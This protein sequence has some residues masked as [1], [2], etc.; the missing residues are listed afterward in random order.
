MGI[1]A[2]ARLDSTTVS[3]LIA[4]MHDASNH[5][6]ILPAD[7]I[8]L[9]YESLRKMHILWAC[10]IYNPILPSVSGLEFDLCHDSLFVQKQYLAEAPGP[11]PLQGVA[12]KGS[13]RTPSEMPQS[14]RPLHELASSPLY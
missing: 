7:E 10:V 2:T 4:L 3:S 5:R 14:R 11:P 6:C 13:T 1:E 8:G 12:F 9:V